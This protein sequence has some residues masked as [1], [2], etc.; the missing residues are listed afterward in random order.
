MTQ[1]WHEMMHP[2]MHTPE[3]LHRLLRYD[4]KTGKLYWRE[5]GVEWFNGDQRHCAKFNT[6]YAGKEAFTATSPQGYKRGTLLGKNYQAHV[7][8]FAMMT[9]RWPDG[10]V[11]H[12]NKK[13]SDN[14]FRNL[15]EGSRAQNLSNTSSRVGSSSR[16]LGVCWDARRKRWLAQIRLNRKTIS[17][18]RYDDESDAARAYDEAAVKLKGEYASTNFGAKQ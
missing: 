15:R 6:R 18:G 14:R 9:G 8:I 2:G 1:S 11:D 5:R 7:V 10:D 13:R 17:L 12:R 3:M 4:P 16:Y